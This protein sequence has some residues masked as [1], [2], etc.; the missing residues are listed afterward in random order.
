MNKIMKKKNVALDHNL[1]R[2]ECITHKI[3]MLLEIL[4]ILINMVVL[5][6][7]F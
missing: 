7:L 2:K 4:N 6:I 3:S 1:Y 5:N